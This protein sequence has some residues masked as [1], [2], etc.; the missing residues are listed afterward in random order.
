MPLP[1]LPAHDHRAPITTETEVGLQTSPLTSLSHNIATT[2]PLL[3]RSGFQWA[4]LGT[5]SL[6]PAL[7]LQPES[8][9]FRSNAPV[10]LGFQ[11]WQVRHQGPDAH[12]QHAHHSP[13]PG[14]APV[15][16]SGAITVRHVYLHF[17][18]VGICTLRSVFAHEAMAQKMVM[19][20]LTLQ[21]YCI[22]YIWG[23]PV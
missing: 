15:G 4:G 6:L 7:F 1:F 12:F 18:A 13:A 16:A 9:S 5:Q 2:L 11:G 22:L 14:N 10:S 8:H 3:S 23:C 21:H 20:P 17:G 19:R